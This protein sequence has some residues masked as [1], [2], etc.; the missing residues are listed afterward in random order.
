MK[1]SINNKLFG[2]LVLLVFSTLLAR[3]PVAHADEIDVPHEVDSQTELSVL[4]E[5]S[6]LTEEVLPA[7]IDLSTERRAYSPDEVLIWNDGDSTFFTDV[8]ERPLSGE[9]RIDGVDYVL[10]S[11]GTIAAGGGKLGTKGRLYVP[12]AGIDVAV[13][14]AKDEDAQ[15]YTDYADSAAY[16]RYWLSK[17]YIADHND[18]AF[19][20]LT[21]VVPGDEAFLFTEKGIE[22]FVCTDVVFG[23]NIENGLTDVNGKELGTSIPLDGFIAYTCLDTWK[24]VQITYWERTWIAS[25]ESSL[26]LVHLDRQDARLIPM[27][28]ANSPTELRTFEPVL[29]SQAAVDTP[30]SML[31]LVKPKEYKRVFPDL[32][33]WDRVQQGT[34]LK[35]MFSTMLDLRPDLKQFCAML[36]Q[37]LAA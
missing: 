7:E 3:V 13:N 8:Y 16:V 10:A 35:D 31:N 24:N 22:A 34:T 18:Q 19:A 27:E 20:G 11:D 5:E 1:S 14:I 17:Y 4:S 21:Q 26:S 15:D 25:T 12:V 36:K 29:V 9:W 32:K 37:R 28:H 30:S 23:H 6:A 2:L 33:I